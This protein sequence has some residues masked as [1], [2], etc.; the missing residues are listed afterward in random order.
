[1]ASGFSRTD[2]FRLPFLPFLPFLPVCLPRADF[3]K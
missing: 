3:D 2:R 1:V